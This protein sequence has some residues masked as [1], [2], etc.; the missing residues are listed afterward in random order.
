M[1]NNDHPART[2]LTAVGGRARALFEG[3]EVADSD[4]ALMLAEPGQAPVCYFPAEDVRMAF[5]R[6]NSRVTTSPWGGVASWYTIN[7]DGKVVENVAWSFERPFDEAVIIAGYI[8]FAPEQVELQL[9]APASVPHVPAHDP[10]Y[11]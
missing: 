4:R 2:R 6:R 3:H 9:D 1:M 11:I 8:A 7:R 5:L 10:P